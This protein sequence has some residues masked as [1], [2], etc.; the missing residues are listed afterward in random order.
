MTVH[1]DLSELEESEASEAEP[2][3]P[4]PA[5]GAARTRQS[6]GASRAAGAWPSA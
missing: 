5:K 2:E 6:K 3:K 4:A 1:S